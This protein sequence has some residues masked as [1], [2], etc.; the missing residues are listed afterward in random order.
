M[1][2]D[3]DAHVGA[4]DLLLFGREWE[5]VGIDERVSRQASKAAGGWSWT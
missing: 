5:G 2:V 4:G 1:A 3:V